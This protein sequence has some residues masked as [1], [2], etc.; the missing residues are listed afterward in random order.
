MLIGIG[1]GRTLDIN[2]EVINKP[3]ADIVD[4]AI[5]NRTADPIGGQGID[6][7]EMHPVGIRRTGRVIGVVD[8]G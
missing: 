8:V 7:I 4:I 6:P 2:P 1:Q 5:N 3:A